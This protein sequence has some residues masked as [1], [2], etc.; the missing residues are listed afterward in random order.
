MN[1]STVSPDKLM[2]RVR[3]DFIGFDRLFSLLEDTG[4]AL[5]TQS[6]PPYNI[7]Q[8]DK[9][10][11]LITLAV[12]G[13]KEEDLVV[14]VQ[15][16]KLVIA[17]KATQEAEEQRVFLHRGIA[18]RAFERNFVLADGVEVKGVIL[19]DGLLTV[20]L[21]RLIPEVRKPKQIEITRVS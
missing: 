14:T 3:R 13:F 1:I 17:G 19:Q 8:V 21:E 15:D 5:N 18:Q 20:S 11:W 2:E 7:E 16:K 10:H 6:Y 4:T 9:E 12:A